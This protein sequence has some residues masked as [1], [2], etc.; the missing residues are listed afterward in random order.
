M[1]SVFCIAT[2]VRLADRM[3]GQLREAEIPSMDV[4]LFVPSELEGDDG[5]RVWWGSTDDVQ[6]DVLDTS[7]CWL[8][9][10]R[11]VTLPDAGSAV[12]IGPIAG[13]LSRRAE[14]G[15]LGE[16]LRRLGLADFETRRYLAELASGRILVA[17]HTNQRDQIQRSEEVFEQC[18]G[19]DIATAVGMRAA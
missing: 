1:H 17:V 6:E 9:R 3:L 18:A 2:S 12:A 11:H 10:F 8:G 7:L 5:L 13:M 19:E 14:G 4:S 16:V 15:G